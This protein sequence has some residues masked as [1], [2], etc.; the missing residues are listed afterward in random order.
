[1]SDYSEQT[2]QTIENLP[3]IIYPY[4]PYPPYEEQNMGKLASFLAGVIT[5][6]VALGVTAC[7]VDKLNKSSSEELGKQPNELLDEN[8]S[9]NEE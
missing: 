2:E 3:T 6:A 7:Y 8:L 1:M 5:G 9:S 4:P